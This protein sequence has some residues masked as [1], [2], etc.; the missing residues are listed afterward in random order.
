MK[1]VYHSDPRGA[2]GSVSTYERPELY[3]EQMSRYGRLPWQ[4]VLDV[5]VY[6]GKT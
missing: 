5:F 4:M 6:S 2:I 3:A 1:Q